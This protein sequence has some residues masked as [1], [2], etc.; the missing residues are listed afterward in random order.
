MLNENEQSQGSLNTK[1]TCY[2]VCEIQTILGVTRQTVY[3]L[4]KK[5]LFKSI[6][7]YMGYRIEKRSFD[8]WLDNEEKE[9]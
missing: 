6:K 9:V 3:K 4:I 8:E 2:K 5:D 1:K 7:T